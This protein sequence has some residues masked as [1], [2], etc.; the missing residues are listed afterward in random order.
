MQDWLY[1]T[2]N[3]WNCLC[4]TFYERLL[5]NRFFAGTHGQEWRRDCNS[6]PAKWIVVRPR[7]GRRVSA[8]KEDEDHPRKAVIRAMRHRGAMIAT[9]EDGLFG[10]WNNAP[11]R[12]WNS[13]VNKPYPDEQEQ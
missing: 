8:A 6:L 1:A 5:R 2:L 7:S 11:P 10:V 12:G 4:E 13:L 9:T 3:A